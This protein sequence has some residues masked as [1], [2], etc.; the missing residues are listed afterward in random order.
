M[1][2]W[3][4]KLARMNGE[5][6]SY[7]RALARLIGVGPA[8]VLKCIG[9]GELE[10]QPGPGGAFFAVLEPERIMDLTGLGRA[11]TLMALELLSRHQILESLGGF[12]YAIY[13]EKISTL[14]EMAPVESEIVRVER[15]ERQQRG[16]SLEQPR[17]CNI[18]G[19]YIGGY[20]GVQDRV[21]V[22][23]GVVDRG[24]IG[25]KEEGE[26]EGEGKE[27]G[28]KK[29]EILEKN[30]SREIAKN[31]ALIPANQGQKGTQTSK[32][33]PVETG[34]NPSALCLAMGPL[35]N[36]VVDVLP[37]LPK[38]KKKP[39][40]TVERI[41]KVRKQNMEIITSWLDDEIS[42]LERRAVGRLIPEGFSGKIT[43][44]T[45]YAL[46]W[47]SYFGANSHK[48]II[49][50]CARYFRPIHLRAVQHDALDEFVAAW[51]EYVAT[52]FRAGKDI[53]YISPAK[54]ASTYKYWV[55]KV[56]KKGVERG[57]KNE[58]LDQTKR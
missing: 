6:V 34:K 14:I 13:P 1:Y 16:C 55:D 27:L 5:A 45:P 18:E 39:G 53:Q 50:Q 15:G 41:Q 9:D 38:P 52:A 8:I 42:Q 23:I 3:Q 32:L 24:V 4:L 20:K 10:F 51:A 26:R 44:L 57:V 31:S 46:V 33:M 19:G 58:R 29:G 37:D 49:G 12:V 25:G 11:E 54:F 28:G 40:K 36:S 43:W 7:S 22:E 2:E 30:Q 48:I 21:R 35:T 56:R 47:D 17:C